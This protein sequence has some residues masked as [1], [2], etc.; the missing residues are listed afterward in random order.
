MPCNVVGATISGTMVL[1]S[2]VMFCVSGLRVLILQYLIPS[3]CVFTADDVLLT[4]FLMHMGTNTS[5]SKDAGRKN[6]FSACVLMHFADFCCRKP[7][8]LANGFA[9]EIRSNSFVD[10]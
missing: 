2:G 1:E 10:A 8:W 6:N 3:I 5:F 7:F 9:N 4:A